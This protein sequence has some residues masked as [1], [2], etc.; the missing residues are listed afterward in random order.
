MIKYR[1][2]RTCRLIHAYSKNKLKAR[3][4]VLKAI[5]RYHNS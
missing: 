2:A 1:Q 5:G 3:D 4:E